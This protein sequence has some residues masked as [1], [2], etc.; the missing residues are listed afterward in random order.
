MDFDKDLSYVRKDFRK[1]MTSFL[2]RHYCWAVRCQYMFGTYTVPT[3]IV[4]GE[5]ARLPLVQQQIAVY[6]LSNHDMS[7]FF[8]SYVENS[9]PKKVWKQSVSKFTNPAKPCGEEE[10]S[11][12]V[13]GILSGTFARPCCFG[14]QCGT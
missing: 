3:G 7:S 10:A 5:K 9:I 12:Q 11:Q 13:P 8:E 2:V 4:E 1:M 6:L 14:L